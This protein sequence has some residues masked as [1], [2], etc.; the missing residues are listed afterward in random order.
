MG[1][2]E[3]QCEDCNGL[4]WRPLTV[5]IHSRKSTQ[6]LPTQ[7]SIL[8]GVIKCYACNLF[9]TD[10]EASCF[11]T[12]TCEQWQRTVALIFATRLLAEAAPVSL[13]VQD[14]SNL[15]S[16]CGAE[17]NRCEHPV[18][19]EE[20]SKLGAVCVGVDETVTPYDT[21]KGPITSLTLVCSKCGAAFGCCDHKGVDMI[22]PN[23]CSF[24]KEVKN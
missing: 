1:K 19:A 18:S 9:A 14:E 21:S 5:E 12:T 23:T 13:V 20:T 10:N 11:V 8:T 22:D 16:V 3:N 4:G 15:C 7:E 6:P 17:Y 24:T 2:V